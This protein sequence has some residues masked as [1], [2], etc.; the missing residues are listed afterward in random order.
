MCGICGVLELSGAPA[1][2]ELVARMTRSISHRGPDGEGIFVDGELGLGH[3]RLAI[4]DLSPAGQQPMSAGQGRFVISYNGEVYNHPE[5][6]TELEALGHRFRSKS[7]T[8]VVLRAWIEWGE[9]SLT[10]LN[11]MFAF[12]LWDAR[13][14]ELTLVR[15]KYG[16]KPLYYAL[17]GQT[18]VFGSEQRAILQH[19]AA[20]RRIDKKALV[21]YL[22]F[23]NIISDRTLNDA[24]RIL[25]AGHTLRLRSDSSTLTLREYWDF[26]FVEPK[27][28]P[29]TQELEEELQ[30]VIR[31]AVKRQ[32]RS[33]VEVGS[34]LSGGL[35]SGTIAALATQESSPLQTFT[36]GFDTA[37]ALAEEVQFD[38]RSAARRMAE[39]LGARHHEIIVGPREF[40]AVL[41]KVVTQL[42]EPRV[43]QSYPNYLVAKLAS[44]HVK[45]VLSGAGGDELFGGYPWRYVSAF[46]SNETETFL[47][48]YFTYWNRL[49]QPEELRQLLAPI[50]SEVS[51]YDPKGVFEGIIRKQIEL[52]SS[53]SSFLNACLYFEAKTF[54]HGLLVVEDKLS[55]AHGLETRLPFLDDDVVNFAMRCPSVL[56][57]STAVGQRVAGGQTNTA[58]IQGKEILRRVLGEIVGESLV[59]LRK[60]GFSA[61]DSGW[62]GDSNRK[63]VEGKL[64]RT[65][66]LDEWGM[67]SSTILGALSQATGSSRFRLLAW[68]VLSLQTLCLG[69]LS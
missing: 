4:V 7:D 18:F 24:I 12:A 6:R 68:S 16:I 23:Q 9:K 50:W 27:S 44:Q 36:C 48:G 10:R 57:V 29:S 5:L 43:G 34:Y 54:L 61:P 20:T 13:A 19:P 8:E 62:F 60:Q 22:T 51:D 14:H 55:M 56:K 69:E 38:E 67:Q 41:E 53:Q 58:P 37:E 21:E 39:H 11:G 59:G 42:E 49:F 46:E 63:F 28:S 15:D 64:S 45:V 25:P 1:N 30:A 40:E 52:S 33:D 2:R 32:M 47:N 66:C 31:Q 26:R 65:K 17:L 35:D 3:R